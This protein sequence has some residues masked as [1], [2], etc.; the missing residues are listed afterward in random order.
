MSVCAYV[1][2]QALCGQVKG[3][4]W[5]KL[6]KHTEAINFIAQ[7]ILVYTSDKNPNPWLFAA[8]L[9][10]IRGDLAELKEMESK[11]IQMISEE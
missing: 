8:D 3:I 11:L 2:Q 1:R 9:E 10:L 5:D 6:E 7:R 4:D